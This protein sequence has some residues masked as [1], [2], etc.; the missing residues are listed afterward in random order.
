[1]S[2]SKEQITPLMKQ[3]LDIKSQYPDTLLF[4]RMGDFYELFFEDAKKVSSLLD[5]TL[6]KRGNIKGEPIP[7]AGIPYHAVDGYLSRLIKQGVSAVICEQSA[8]PDGSKT[9][10]VRN[11]SKIVTPGT[12]TDEGIAPDSLDNSIAC[13][14]K[15]KN[16]YALSTLSLSSGSFTTALA[17]DIK[18]ITL[19]LDKASPVELLY[20]ENFKETQ[21]FSDIACIKKLP[22]WSFDLKSCYKTLCSQF[23]TSSLFGFDIENLDECIS[24]SGAL[25]SYV[26]DTQN[27]SL[28]HI[29][30]IVRDEQS[31]YV[32]L[33]KCAQRNLE[34]LSN[35]RGEEQG[36]LL[37]ILDKT[38]TPM[39]S[40]LLK[41]WLIQPLLDNSKVN[42]RLDIIENLLDSFPKEKLEEILRSIGDIE[43]IVARVALNTA[44]PKDLST[45]RDALNLIPQIKNLIAKYG[46]SSMSDLD[47]ALVD[48]KEIRQLLQSAIKD[49]PSTLLRDGGVIA[50]GYNALLDEL[51][52]L[53]SGSETL[54]SEIEQREREA[55]GINTLKVN[56]NQVHGY[57]IEVTKLNG[58]KVPDHYIRRQTLKNSERFITPE[59]KDLEERTLNAKAQSLDIE[60]EIFDGI[61]ATLQSEI[62]SLDM[63]AK[64]ISAFDILLS[65][66][67]VSEL[68]NYTRPE[69]TSQ[70]VITIR[71]GRHPV[72][73]KLNSKPFVA[74]SID[75]NSKKVF[76]ISGPNMG[77]KSTFMR[78]VAL[79]TIMARIGCFVPAASARIGHID[80]IFTRIGASDDL[81]SGRSTFMV[82]MEE[83]ASI[84][85]N[86]TDNSLV[87]MDEVGRGTST[88]EGAALALSIARYLCSSIKAMT[89]FSTHYGELLN[90]DSSYAIAQNICF[91][92][93]EIKNKI[94][95]LYHAYEG[96]QS[97]S[98]GIEVG[99]LA[100]LPNAVIDQAK[101]DIKDIL[102][103][104]SISQ[105]QNTLSD[106]SKENTE[107]GADAHD[108]DD[109][110]TDIIDTIKS[111]D[112]N[113][114]TP[115]EALNLLSALKARIN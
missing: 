81:S 70:S 37:N 78:Q 68:N 98:Y 56:F 109:L 66:A 49:T 12:V 73:E 99:K 112:L 110:N 2:D 50:D 42:K 102:D 91:K 4:F 7:M 82:E 39:G 14:F 30:N 21:I 16:Y 20:P 29:R 54:L 53:M 33:D 38:L 31:N 6:T 5:L 51:R 95:F 13:I 26:K 103:K 46:N 9:I 17:S 64:A 96:S 111:A 113:C 41:K 40:R 35:L 15:G 92:A 52:S 69:I 85:N 24:A 94:V 59:L 114:M 27:V 3:Y 105:I 23:N 76:I 67:R 87:L 88:T 63:I 48:L 36:S 22:I 90:L 61:I 97:Y 18:G 8:A 65:F 79:I 19:Y 75:F 93:Q 80:R 86:A 71:E 108:R 115:L 100:G 77:G 89:L 25:L 32:V 1:M 57:Y 28:Q 55:T 45:L 58:D 104:G 44:R 83:A 84:L 72:V 34:L 11:V 107:P 47:S 74:N 60:K 62:P 43:R 106:D 10:M 101:K